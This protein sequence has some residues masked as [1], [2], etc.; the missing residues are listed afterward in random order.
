METLD[1][2]PSRS[3]AGLIKWVVLTG[4]ESTGKT[5]LA[6]RL[7]AYYQTVWVPEYVRLFVERKQALPELTD[8]P[9]IAQGHIDTADALAR[10][11][12]RVLLCDTDLISTCLYS[13]FYY[14]TCPDWIWRASYTRPA[15]L[16]L[17]AEPDIP[18]TPDPGQRDG[19]EARTRLHQQFADELVKRRLPHLRLPGPL[20]QRLSKAIQAIDRLL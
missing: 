5:T 3:N 19:P 8:V 2:P 15:H 4:A 13:T 7:A 14:G 20:D 17:L 18:W 12:N 11:A 16:Y 1:A 10:Q 9:A 6:E